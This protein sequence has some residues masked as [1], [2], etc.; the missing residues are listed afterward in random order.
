MLLWTRSDAFNE[1]FLYVCVH[2]LSICN[3]GEVIYYILYCNTKIC[4]YF[5]YRFLKCRIDW[6]KCTRC[7]QSTIGLVQA[8][9]K[10]HVRYYLP[11]FA[12]IRTCDKEKGTLFVIFLCAR[13]FLHQY[14]DIISKY[15]ISPF[16]NLLCFMLLGLPFAVT[17]TSHAPYLQATFFRKSTERAN[18]QQARGACL[19]IAQIT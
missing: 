16:F 1:C 18:L 11:Q 13:K 7:L 4:F 5:Y 12:V 14:I 19:Y 2:V 3:C 15:I 6:G 10:D 9:H 8:S 17:L